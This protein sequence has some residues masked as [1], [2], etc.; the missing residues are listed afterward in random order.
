MYG[1]LF[2]YTWLWSKFGELGSAEVT[3]TRDEMKKLVERLHSLWNTGEVSAISD[4]YAPD[5]IGHFSKGS[6]PAI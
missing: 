6:R 1:D 2:A 4:L 3:M 5:F